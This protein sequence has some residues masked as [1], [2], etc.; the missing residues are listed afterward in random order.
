MFNFKAQALVGSS[1]VKKNLCICLQKDS[2]M[3]S[4]V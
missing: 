2:I 3:Q 1:M 4:V